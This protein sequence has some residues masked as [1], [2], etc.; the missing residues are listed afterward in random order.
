[1]YPSPVEGREY[2]ERAVDCLEKAMYCGEEMS[3]VTSKRYWLLAGDPDL[4]RLRRYDTFRAFEARIYVHPLPATEKIGRYEL[5][6]YLR[7]WVRAAADAVAEEW[8]KRSAA[9]DV[10]AAELERWWDLELRAWSRRSASAASIVS[11][12]H[13][14][15]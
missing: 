15:R 10:T 8:R 9:V 3:F 13:A 5:Y 7:G 4:A 14:R 6:A 11:G 12:R 1:M 2:A